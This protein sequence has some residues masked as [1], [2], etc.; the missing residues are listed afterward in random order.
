MIRETIIR[1][2]VE[3]ELGCNSLL[4]ERIAASDE[5]LHAAAINEFGSWETALEYA[6]V[7]SH[8]VDWCR[9]LTPERIKRR[10]RRLCTTGYDLGAKVNRSRD[11]ALYD[12]AVRHFG[13]WRDA[14]S[15]AGIDMANVTYRRPKNLD[16]NGMILWIQ[17]RKATGQS[18]RFCDVCPEKRDYVFDGNITVE[19]I[20][21]QGNRITLGIV[22]PAEV[23]VLRGELDQKPSQSKP[24]TTKVVVKDG[25]LVAC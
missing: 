20:R 24:D 15:S 9:A 23:K 5:L 12:A 16:R 3:L 18:L 11:R 17:N 13:G 19:V 2:I 6:G 10:L 8:N 1:K 14:L 4:D 22:A 25:L 21:I 7:S